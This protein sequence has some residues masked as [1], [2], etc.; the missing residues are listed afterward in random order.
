[1]L[2][3]IEQGHPLCAQIFSWSGYPSSKE[4]YNFRESELPP[5]RL[6]ACPPSLLISSFTPPLPAFFTVPAQ[7][8]ALASTPCTV[9][10][11]YDLLLG[12]KKGE[13]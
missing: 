13:R 4:N 9:Y 12:F 11:N 8:L 2:W 7:C 3:L 1:M 5:I 6:S 10:H